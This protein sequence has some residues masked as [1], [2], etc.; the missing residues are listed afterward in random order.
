MN[1]KASRNFTWKELECKCGCETRCIDPEAIR[2]LQAL[3]D[4]LGKPVHINSAARC[5]R[6]NLSVGG[7]K[8]SRHLS[9]VNLDTGICIQRSDAFDI[10]LRNQSVAEVRDQAKL[11][12]FRGIGI[13]KSFIHIDLRPRT[14]EWM[15]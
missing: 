1:V 15:Y 13:Y 3:R 8:K 14:Y 9:Q 4:R 10:S 6:H 2:L 5:P 11:V 12:G 7:A